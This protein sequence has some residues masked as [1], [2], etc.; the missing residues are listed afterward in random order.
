MSSMLQEAKECAC[1]ECV[2]QKASIN[3]TASYP[4]LSVYASVWDYNLGFT[5][6]CDMFVKRTFRN[7]KSD[8]QRQKP[9]KKT[10]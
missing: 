3:R 6:F 2:L 10:H 7:A 4:Q 5:V 1:V 8:V 9:L